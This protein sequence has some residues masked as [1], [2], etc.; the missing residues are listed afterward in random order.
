MT[1]YVMMYQLMLGEDEPEKPQGIFSD[2]CQGCGNYLNNNSGF[3]VFFCVVCVC[4]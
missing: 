4:N 2:H 3:L 1:S